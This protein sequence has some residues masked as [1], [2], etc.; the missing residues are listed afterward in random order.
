MSQ[1]LKQTGLLALCYLT[2]AS[3]LSGEGG[4]HAQADRVHSNPGD[5]TATHSEGSGMAT[6]FFKAL[7]WTV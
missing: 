6:V 3:A 7:T 5:S 4:A 2:P 1:A